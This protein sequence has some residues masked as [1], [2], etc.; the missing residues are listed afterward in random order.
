MKRLIGLAFI[1]SIFLT[2]CE[3]YNGEVKFAESVRIGDLTKTL[4]I[5]PES[6]ATTTEEVTTVEPTTEVTTEI[7][8]ETPTSE[9]VASEAT[10]E[11][12]KPKFELEV[13]KDKDN[14]V[15]NY[16]DLHWTM[17]KSVKLEDI[18][19]GKDTTSYGVL[20]I[21]DAGINTEI[22]KGASQDIVDDYDVC[23]S[24]NYSFCGSPKPVLLC[25]HKTRSFSKLYDVKKNDYIF[26][27]TNYGK[28]VYRV[29]NTKIGTV[30]SD[31]SN[32]VDDDGKNIIVPN[33]EYEKQVLQIYT[34]YGVDRGVQRF[35]VT[36]KLIVG[37]KIKQ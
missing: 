7:A 8:S 11:A 36:A 9:E 19:F 28:Y 34:C 10:T 26:I 24:T 12:E 35:V 37:T 2:G 27:E 1:L 17:P 32:I 6:L 15:V 30:T 14:I 20:L 3:Q 13:S 16:G 33:K 22:I 23:I 25:G 18:V 31:S 4:K 29:L 21:P 5:D